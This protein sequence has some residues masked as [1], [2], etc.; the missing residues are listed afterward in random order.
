[1]D[2]ADGFAK[3]VKDTLLKRPGRH[4]QIT[5][6]NAGR[7]CPP[8]NLFA[9][10]CLEDWAFGYLSAAQVQAYNAL[11]EKDNS[12]AQAF[13]HKMMEKLA[14]LGTNGKHRQ[15]I[16]RELCAFMRHY[17]V[18]LKPKII[19]IPLYV[20]KGKHM[21]LHTLDFGWIPPHLWFHFLYHNYPEDFRS[22][23][24]GPEGAITEFWD[25]VK[26]NDP[27]RYQNHFMDHPRL[28]THGIPIA[29]FGDGVPC[30]NNNTLDTLGWQSLL[31]LADLESFGSTVDYIFLM[32]AV[33]SK[34]TAEDGATKRSIWRAAIWSIRA[35]GTGK[36]PLL[37]WDLNPFT[38]GT[39]EHML[40]DRELAGGYFLVTWSLKNDTEFGVNHY[41]M[42]GHW[43]SGHPCQDCDANKIDLSP[44][45]WSN[46]NPDAP[47]KDHTFMIVDQ[48]AAHCLF[49]GKTLHPV[50]Q[51]LE[52]GGLGLSPMMRGKDGLHVLDLGTTMQVNGNVLW[53]LVYR[54]LP[55]EPEENMKVIWLQIQ[56]LYLTRGVTSQFAFIGLSMFCNPKDPEGDFPEM[57]GKGAE[58]RH[59]APILLAV[60]RQFMR[61]GNAYDEHIER[62]LQALETI[63]EVLEYKTDDGRVPFFLKA[64][65]I[66]TLRK[67]ID[68][69]LLHYGV[70]TQDAL[71]ANTLLW[72]LRPKF[73]F[74]WHLG[75]ESEYLNP[76]IVW[77]Y[78]CED[79][80]GRMSTLGTSTRHGL[81]AAR[82]SVPICEQWCLG[83]S[84]RMH[85]AGLDRHRRL[86]FWDMLLLAFLS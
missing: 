26:A 40:I 21:G 27:K 25:G 45:K 57:G 64:E 3:V 11:V 19:Q 42:P 85:H 51:S 72:N 20:H 18:A 62:M 54:R 56:E 78:A 8:R 6:A 50:F 16:S 10:R 76:R 24:L 35:A 71:A 83:Q 74:L 66:E 69:F 37:D 1:M 2:D 33:F 63:Y 15:N 13:I 9:E 65:Q 82:R 28:R 80:V 23:L 39:L 32:A 79:W 68:L 52:S 48:L 4:L 14:S 7:P 75:L 59:L 44:S 29:I 67:S 46:F 47:W 49:K 17:V 60:W 73:H 58:N 22:R 70:L 61:R 41:E 30:T 53:Q 55:G 5:A 34:S 43:S 36:G 38:P 77:N 86:G 84:L 31:A 81:G 12:A